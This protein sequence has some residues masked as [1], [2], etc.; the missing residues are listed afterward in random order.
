MRRGMI[1]A[2]EKV[3]KKTGGSVVKTA[4]KIVG[5]GL[6]AG[7]ALIAATDK[8]MK[9]AFPQEDEGCCCGGDCGDDCHCEE[10]EECNCGGEDCH[11]G[12]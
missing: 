3:T 11:C 10:G 12:H 1:K 8:T 6:A 2:D 4:M 9:A 5:V 7:V